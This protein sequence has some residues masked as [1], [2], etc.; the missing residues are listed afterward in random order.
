MLL[1]HFRI[2]GAGNTA[3]TG[4]MLL[5]VIGFSLIPLVVARGEGV[6]NPLLFN[7]GWRLGV[8]LGCLLVLGVFYR[9]LIQK[10]AILNMIRERIF[11]WAIFSHCLAVFTWSTRYIDIS[12]A[13]ILLETWPILSI[14][15]TKKLFERENR[16]DRTSFTTIIFA[17]FGFAGFMFVFASQSTNLESLISIDRISIFGLFFGVLLAISAAVVGAIESASNFKWGVNVSKELSSIPG[18]GKKTDTLDLFCVI[19]AFTIV[20]AVSAPLHVVGGIFGGESIIDFIMAYDTLIIA[21]IGGGVI[22][23][24]S[25][26]FYRVAILKTDDLGINALGYAISILSLI[27]LAIFYRIGVE[28]VDY[29][30]IGATVIIT[31]NLLINFEAEIR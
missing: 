16:F 9:S 11:S 29:L 7:A 22:Q 25:S 24:F 1:S 27:W 20:S 4:Y 6:E 14:I 13:V 17:A 31:I 2:Y 15:F 3:A 19:I 23:A 8:V 21:V 28:R 26:V 5:A 18:I 30:A 12:I 10:T